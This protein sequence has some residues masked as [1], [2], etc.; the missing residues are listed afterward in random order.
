MPAR[1][2]IVLAVLATAVTAAVCLCR[3]HRRLAAALCAEQAARRLTDAAH[4]RDVT[5]L[6][7]EF[8]LRLGRVVAG[9]HVLA[10]ADQVV[11]DAYRSYRPYPE[12]G[13]P[14]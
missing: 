10:A 11:D 5:A 6:E 12:G 8:A 7:A 9:T 4:H 13:H 14:Q 2:V 3:R 1:P